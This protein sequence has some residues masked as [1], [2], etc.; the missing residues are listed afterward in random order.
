[1][2][3][4]LIAVVAERGSPSYGN[5]FIYDESGRLLVSN[6]LDIGNRCYWRQ[7]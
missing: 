5:L 3:S 1:M 7:G 2:C 6:F 4:D